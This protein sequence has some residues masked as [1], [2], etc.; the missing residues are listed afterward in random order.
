V[1]AGEGKFHCIILKGEEKYPYFPRPLLSDFEF[2]MPL[3]TALPMPSDP[4]SMDIE[5]QTSTSTLEH[6]YVLNAVLASLVQD[7]IDTTR[8]TA[9][10][11]A[12]L[13]RREGESDKALLQL[14][15]EECRLG[16]ERGMKALEICTLMPNRTG[17]MFELARK[18]A[19]RFNRDMLA[20]KIDELEERRLA[21]ADGGAIE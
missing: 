18:V 7:A 10:Q 20:E 6:T 1:A 16:E 15:A 8:A 5:G 19:L 9:S 12:E 4:D 14:L 13:Q 3:G 11:Y 2:K 17:R 21:D